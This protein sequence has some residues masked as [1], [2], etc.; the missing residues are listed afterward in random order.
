M[1]PQKSDCR[2]A[3]SLSHSRMLDDGKMFVDIYVR[4]VVMGYFDYNSGVLYIS[5]TPT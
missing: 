5:Q 4:Y 3:V 2:L 1:N